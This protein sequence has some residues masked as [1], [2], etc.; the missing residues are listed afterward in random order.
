[1][2]AISSKQLAAFC[3]VLIEG[4]RLRL[5][6][7]CLIIALSFLVVARTTENAA[8]WVELYLPVVGAT[9]LVISLA[10]AEL[11]ILINRQ[12][13]LH[14]DR[15]QKNKESE[16]IACNRQRTFN[17]IWQ[18]LTD[19]PRGGAIEQDVIE[20]LVDLFSADLVAVWSGKESSVGY[21]LAGAH[22]LSLEQADRLN[23]IGQVA[24][25]FSQLKE[26]GRQ[27]CITDFHKQT[28][29]ALAWFC[30]DHDLSYAVFS[31]VQVRQEIV[32]VLGIFYQQRQNLSAK[33]LEEMQAA[34][35]LLLCA[36]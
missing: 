29:P 12:R 28:A 25:C 23:K 4:A 15:E 21:H 22:H 27:C 18:T 2:R 11:Q 17:H 24:P 6:G 13:Q 14:L 34:A 33:K 10:G 3:Q 30:H 8:G 26:R 36:L 1:M 31:P 5:Y 35:N 16:L 9:M 7:M 20:S 32:G 19:S